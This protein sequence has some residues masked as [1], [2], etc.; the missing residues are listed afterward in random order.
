MPQTQQLISTL[1]HALKAHKKTYADVAQA[2]DLSEASVKRLFA[3]R[4]LSLLRLEEA[5]RLVD[6]EISDLVQLMNQRSQQISQ[7]TREQ[8]A[9]IAGDRVLLLVTVCVL[10]RW[11]LA[12]VLQHFRITQPQAI[13][14]LARLDRLKIVE[15]LPGDRIKLLIS[16]NFHWLENGPIQQLFHAR[17]QDDFFD[18]RFDRPTERLLVVNGMLSHRSNAELQKRMGRLAREFDEL[19]DQDAGLPLD[20]RHGVTMVVAMSDWRFGLFADLRR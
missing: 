3:G 9:E 15:L 4:N 5:C 16:P 7:L 17:L 19:N 12:Q 2:W 11:T 13:R 10:N 20:Q 8:E 6:M 14:C 1:K 18:S